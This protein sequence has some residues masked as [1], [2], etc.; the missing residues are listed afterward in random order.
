MPPLLQTRS[1]WRDGDDDDM[2]LG[3]NLGTPLVS[4]SDSMMSTLPEFEELAS[5]RESPAAAA[6]AAASPSPRLKEEA[7]AL[8]ETLELEQTQLSDEEALYFIDYANHLKEKQQTIKDPKEKNIIAAMVAICAQILGAKGFANILGVEKLVWPAAKAMMGA[9]AAG[10]AALQSYGP[11]VVDIFTK[12]SW[13]LESFVGHYAGEKTLIALTLMS[14]I[15]WARKQGPRAAAVQLGVDPSQLGPGVSEFLN[16]ELDRIKTERI[17]T[18]SAK[19]MEEASLAYGRDMKSRELF[20]TA[21]QILGFAYE[22]YPTCPAD[23]KAD[24]RTEMLNAITTMIDISKG[25]EP[26][27]LEKLK[28]KLNDLGGKILEPIDIKEVM[29]VIAQISTLEATIAGL[30]KIA[31]KAEERNIIH[32]RNSIENLQ[33]AQKDMVEL[34][35]KK[36]TLLSEALKALGNFVPGSFIAGK[37]KDWVVGM[38]QGGAEAVRAA[39][40]SLNATKKLA[41]A[42]L[43]TSQEIEPGRMA[44][45]GNRTQLGINE[46]RRAELAAEASAASVALEQEG[47]RRQRRRVGGLPG[48]AALPDPT[49]GGSRRRKKSSRKQRNKRKTIRRKVVKKSLRKKSL[50]KTKKNKRKTKRM[51]R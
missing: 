4:V 25:Q 2:D 9:A 51:R 27:Y 49:D 36:Q 31:D 43:K 8:F 42:A 44:V 12:L 40:V 29:K 33:N 46:K 24:L 32:K 21:K 50:R 23:K 10:F 16:A 13:P 3:M 20:E 37:V 35:E 22:A 34:L 45:R 6:A 5:V 7:A 1:S 41:A 30:K 11:S 14:F 19:M 38:T 47:T 15:L 48:P 17:T 18:R 26:S 39:I 28:L